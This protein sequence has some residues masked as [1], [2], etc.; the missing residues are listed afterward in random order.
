MASKVRTALI[1]TALSVEYLAVRAGLTELEKKV[2]RDGT[3]VEVGALGGSDWRVAIVQL[4]PGVVNAAAATMQAIALVNPEV[5]L[6]SGIAGSLKPDICV[7]DVVVGTKIYGIHGGKETVEGF[8]TRPDVWLASYSLSQAAMAALRE[9]SRVHYKPIASG[10]VVI[11]SEGSEL[12]AFLQRHYND[13]C[14]IEMEGSGAAHAAHVAAGLPTLVIRGI[15]DLADSSKEQRDAQG[16]QKKASERAAKAV[17]ATL[18]EVSASDGSARLEGNVAP[19]SESQW[20]ACIVEWADGARV[21][22]GCDLDSLVREVVEAAFAGREIVRQIVGWSGEVLVSVAVGASS[23]QLAYERLLDGFDAAVNDRFTDMKSSG[24]PILWISAHRGEG[25]FQGSHFAGDVIT[26][27][28]SYRRS[29][30]LR[31]ALAGRSSLVSTVCSD[32]VFESRTPHRTR[33][34]EIG[35][36]VSMDVIAEVRPR[37]MWVRLKT[38]ADTHRQAVLVGVAVATTSGDELGAGA[39]GAK[40]RSLVQD[41]CAN[42]PDSWARHELEFRKW[43]RAGFAVVVT[44]EHPE[45]LLVGSLIPR[46]AKCL[47]VENMRSENALRLSLGLHSGSRKMQ[48]C[49]DDVIVADRLVRTSQRMEGWSR[50]HL[51]CLM[52]AAARSSDPSHFEDF[53]DPSRY[54][55]VEAEGLEEQIDS[56][57]YIPYI[58]QMSG[59]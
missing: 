34:R 51:L 16:M 42:A 7:E 4:G 58:P 46:L 14:A 21:N 3:R 6:F 53:V 26:E 20:L 36:W 50:E 39:I 5:M 15:S 8:S 9:D 56:W 17:F 18:R 27:L 19:E 47:A 10:D 48:V 45:T 13:A 25:K 33:E 41:I 44:N 40:V 43:G 12:R 57:L 24:R 11:A 30:G 59:D 1:V 32:E 28:N 52:S 38:A 22:P 37:R 31:D 23:S 55:Q 35:S 49:E 2:H 54:V 29:P